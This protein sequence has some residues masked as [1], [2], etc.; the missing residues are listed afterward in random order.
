MAEM[1]NEAEDAVR[2]A[3]KEAEA[4]ETRTVTGDAGRGHFLDPAGSTMSGKLPGG[5]RDEAGVLHRAF[6]VR[7]MTGVEE[8]L[9]GGKGSQMVRMNRIITNCLL[10]LGTVSDKAIIATAVQAMPTAD[11]V[12][13]LLTLRR[14]SLGDAY[15]LRL[16][17]PNEDC[18]VEDS[19]T[20]SLGDLEVSDMAQPEQRQF[21]TVCP[22]GRRV[23][24]HVMTGAD[25]EWM[26]D[27]A[28]RRHDDDAFTLSFLARMD[29]IDGEPVR[30][31]TGAKNDA[32]YD[33]AAARVKALTVRERNDV[34]EEVVALE[35]GVDTT[36]EFECKQC[37]HT[38]ERSL[39]IG[40]PDFFFRSA[41]R[42][43]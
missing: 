31:G 43:R 21:E 16:K 36:V 5:F 25:E 33:L 22:S 2:V 17:C 4:A 6:V 27:V 30:R 24:W 14:L 38:W 18:L 3:E 7:E 13:V 9:L 39:P 8:D 32:V 42:K 41:K 1:F 37:H 40:G 23:G 29:T 34:R 19:Y 35:G 28:K 26:W 15:V 20:V 10:S 11:R 12:A